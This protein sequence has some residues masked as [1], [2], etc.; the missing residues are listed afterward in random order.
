[1]LNYFES[2]KTQLKAT[3][4]RARAKALAGDHRSAIT[5]VESRLLFSADTT[6]GI[7]T[8]QNEYSDFN[9]DLSKTVADADVAILELN[10]SD[11]N[12]NVVTR[13]EIQ[14]QTVSVA[15]TNPGI[16]FSVDRNTSLT[17]ND[18]S[19]DAANRDELVA[20]LNSD[21][22]TPDL[23]LFARFF[24]SDTFT[25]GNINIDASHAVASDLTISINGENLALFSG[26]LIFSV[27]G[28]H[29]FTSTSGTTLSVDADDIILFRPTLI[30]NNDGSTSFDYSSG[31]FS[32][33]ITN[34]P[35]S[36]SALT[37]IEQNSNFNG[38]QLAS[39]SLLVAFDDDTQIYLANSQSDGSVITRALT[40]LNI[41][42]SAL[43]NRA[44]IDALEFVE[45]ETTVAGQTFSSSTILASF[46]QSGTFGDAQTESSDVIQFSVSGAAQFQG[47]AFT[48]SD[49]NLATATADIN[50]L[51]LLATN[52]ESQ[53]EN[54]TP[55]GDIVL[56]GEFLEGQ[57]ITADTSSVSDPE[58]LGT[59]RYQWLRD[60]SSIPGA[61][62]D[63][64]T[65]TNNDVGARISVQISY[66][67]GDR[68]RES[69]ISAESVAVVN[70]NSEPVGTPRING[71]AVEG[72]S[73]IANTGSIR[74]DDGLGEFSYQWLRD[75]VAISG[76]TDT[77]YLLTGDD[78][79]SAISLQIQYVDNQGTTET[80]LSSQTALVT[81]A[82][83]QDI[84]T[85]SVLGN[86]IEEQTLTADVLVQ[87]GNGVAYTPSDLTYQ[88][89]RNGLAIDGANE[90]SY[91]SDDPD[92]GAQL[93]VQISFTNSFG[94]A[95]SFISEQSQTITAINDN[96]VGLPEIMGI[97]EQGQALVANI[98]NVTDNDGLGTINYQW[99]RNGALISGATE[100]NYQTTQDDVGAE[101]SVQ[102]SYQD[103]QGFANQIV[104]DT[105]PIIANLNDSPQGEVTIDGTAREEQTLTANLNAITDADG[106]EQ[107]NFQWY[108][109]GIAITG[110]TNQ[111]FTIDD[112]DVASRLS[113]AVTYTDSGGTLETL[114]SQDS[115]EITSVNDLPQGGVSI[116]T[117]ADLQVGS[118]LSA[119]TT[120]LNDA[121]GLGQL[122]FQW[123]RDGQ[124]ISGATSANYQLSVAD[125]NT[126]LTLEITYLDNQ[127][128]AESVFSNNSVLFA[129]SV[130]TPTDPPTDPEEVPPPEVIDPPVVV[131]PP[132]V[133][134]PPM[135][136]IPEPETM[137]EV[138]EPAA[139]VDVQVVVP[140]TEI[141]TAT[142]T[143]PTTTTPATGSGTNGEDQGEPENTGSQSSA[144]DTS[145]DSSSANFSRFTLDPIDVGNGVSVEI[146]AGERLTDFAS[147][148]RD[149][150]SSENQIATANNV[151]TLA[152]NSSFQTSDSLFTGFD[153][154][155]AD[156]T[157][158]INQT[159]SDEFEH[160]RAKFTQVN[161][162][163]GV[164]WQA[165]ASITAGLSAGY[166]IWLARGGLVF[167]SVLTSLPAWR[168]IDP[169]PILT[170]G[171][172]G[173]DDQGESLE[174]LVSH[175]ATPKNT[176]SSAD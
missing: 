64:Y 93:S 123:Y 71:N 53:N 8:S 57:E 62:S 78:V 154:L 77:Q 72:Q 164:L 87:D 170:Q 155:I 86:T 68:N 46:N 133:I 39:G 3:V 43:G 172:S 97:F 101:L 131:D 13:P 52:F 146:L 119:E 6:L 24:G 55:Q 138:T 42:G 67:D 114:F 118:L 173:R 27:D 135:V 56:I 31:E 149:V 104:S 51:S 41:N 5:P 20:G 169:L 18:G 105:T 70:V 35:D 32:S 23:D 139:P 107:F 159:N 19:V 174:S 148:F 10:K 76:A 63:T 113:V 2:I 37:L 82:N 45:V 49:L 12:N 48:G 81:A 21:D 126:T 28:R 161:V 15:I 165:A 127:G 141:P 95:Q 14:R 9:N 50:S 73:L 74:D 22:A 111:S 157:L 121:D 106:L 25:N 166:A 17:A 110:A 84:A 120:S 36:V 122:S 134:D 117:G 163:S 65:L 83:N 90:S 33:L 129:P 40:D 58:G 160:L 91:F 115:L 1:M 61:T 144:E 116:A 156:L 176:T 152:S 75:G 66:T 171:Y 153:T 60:G 100:Q 143:T 99:L 30:N 112:I 94:V 145:Q 54:T 96:P 98:S 137:P 130:E 7:D 38:E 132:E 124:A 168:F 150:S 142:T 136:I 92:V 167:T 151:F 85:A 147:S 89:L 44:G 128:T 102:I 88:W 59:F 34:L 158:V 108:R 103:Q 4:S 140:P 29:T 175:Q 109:N 69:L 16:I 80:L 47:I 125:S 79:G 162:E 11:A 26:D